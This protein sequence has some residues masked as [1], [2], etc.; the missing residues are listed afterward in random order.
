[1]NALEVSGGRLSDGRPDRGAP[2]KRD[3]VDI[4]VL[5][6]R[7]TDLATGAGDEIRDPLRE[8]RFL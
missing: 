5:G 7:R 4:I 2:G 3:A 6:Q 1:L 8:T